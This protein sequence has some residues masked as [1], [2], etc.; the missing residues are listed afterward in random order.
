MSA[1]L[2]VDDNPRAA[3]QPKT[4]RLILKRLLDQAV[5]DKR[6]QED[7]DQVHDVVLKWADLETGG[8][9]E[10][11]GETQLQG[12]FLADIF[13]T[14][15]GYA[16]PTDEGDTWS[17]EQH[18]T[19]GSRVPDAILGKLQRDNLAGLRAVVELK[20]AKVHLDRDRSNG[21]TAVDQCWDY[22]IDTPRHCRWGIV[23]NFV[24]FRL[25]ERDSTKRRYEHFSLQSLRDKDTF[26]RFYALFHYAGLVEGPVRSKPR[27]QELFRKTSERQ[28]TV[29]DELYQLYSQRRIYLIRELHIERGIGLAQAIEHTQR[30]FDRIIFIA[31]CE[32]RDLLPKNTLA[33]TYR[34][35]EG[36][37]VENPRWS[38]YVDLFKMV[39][40]G[41][42]REDIPPY[43]GGLFKHGELDL[44]DLPDEP[45][46]SFFKALGGYD[47]A[48]E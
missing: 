29:G 38:A 39:D 31:F 2:F 27:T 45:L 35:G 8:T 43:N 41:W 37:A 4:D 1:S 33:K 9:L 22:L 15:L 26:Y 42:P 18:R 12:D 40:Q 48:D 47:F 30:L 32:D 21:R 24:S 13:G 5:Q 17:L 25:Y 44:L 16:R 6:L 46:T 3:R 34:R 36:R 28:R 14:V 10:T 7:A 23:S 19:V 11:L 20:G